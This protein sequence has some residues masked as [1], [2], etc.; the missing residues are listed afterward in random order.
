MQ[1]CFLPKGGG[2]DQLPLEHKVFLHFFV[3]FEKVNLPRYIFHHMLWA[4]KEIQEKNRIFIPYGRLMSEIFHQGGILKVI[5]FSKAVNDDQLGTV[6]GKFRNANTLKNTLQIKE[7]TKQDSDLQESMI[8]SNLM[9]D[10]PP[11]SNEDP[12]E[13]RAIYV[14]EHWKTNGEVINYSFIPDTMYGAPLKIASNERK[15]KKATS[16]AAEGEASE[17]KPKKAKKEKATIQVNEFGSAMP[18]IQ[19]EVK[20]LEPAKILSRRTRSETSTGS[21]GAIPP[22]HIRKMKVS[23]YMIQEDAKIEDDTDLVTRMESNKKRAVVEAL[24]IA[25]EIEVLAEALLKEST[26][27]DAHKVVELAGCIQELV[28]GNDLLKIAEGV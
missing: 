9:D 3:T 22:Q 15:S 17:P 7:V 4:L 25:K 21:S 5:R 12:P 27:E 20:D 10:F 1:E 8:L 23:N 24:V 18:T 14:N 2:V 6:V 11:I 26:V 13:V 16:E 28:V 19:E